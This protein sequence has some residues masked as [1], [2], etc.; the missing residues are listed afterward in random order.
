[1][2]IP[3]GA[4]QAHLDKHQTSKKFQL[5]LNLHV[6]IYKYSSYGALVYLEKIHQTITL[7]LEELFSLPIYNAT[8]KQGF[9]YL[10]SE[11]NELMLYFF[12]DSKQ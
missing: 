9:V 12:H 11:I 1:M 3:K 4:D 10:K 6:D 2:V 7:L 5:P 8:N